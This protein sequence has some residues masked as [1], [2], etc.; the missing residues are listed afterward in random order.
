MAQNPHNSRKQSILLPLITRLRYRHDKSNRNKKPKEK[1]KK[2]ATFT[3]HSAKVRAITNLLKT[4]T[5]R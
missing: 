1:G 4:Q 2:W 3:H 5:S